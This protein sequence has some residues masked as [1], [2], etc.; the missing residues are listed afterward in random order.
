MAAQSVSKPIGI[1]TR[2]S[3][4]GRRSNEELLSHDLQR[5]KV[6]K[7]LDAR[8]LTASRQ[9]YRDN[10]KS[11][12]SMSR[13]AFDRVLGEVTE[14]KLGG[15]AVAY[16]DRFARTVIEALAVIEK[17]EEAG[18]VV[19]ALDADFDTSTAMGKAMLR[20]SLIFSTLQRDMSIE[21]AVYLAETKLD[22]G[23][24][25]GG[26][27]PVGYRWQ[28]TGSDSNGKDILGWIEP[29]EDAAVV[30][31]ALEGFASGRFTTAGKV[32]D[33]LNAADVTTSKGGRWDRSNIIGLLKRETYTGARRYGAKRIEK[34]HEALIDE[35]THRVIVRRLTPKTTITRKRGEGHIL[36]QG[37]CR[38]GTCGAG[39]T[40]GVANGRYPTL[41]CNSRGVGHTSISYQVAEDWVTSVAFSHG[42]VEDYA[43]SLV[44]LHSRDA[45]ETRVTEAR[46]EVAKVEDM[47]G[48]TLPS[49]STQA[50]ALA[51]AEDALYA[52]DAEATRG[53]APVV[54]NRTQFEALDIAGRIK[55]LRSIVSEVVVFPGIKGSSADPGGRLVVRFQDGAQHPAIW[56]PAS[57][58]PIAVEVTAATG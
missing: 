52:F 8:E 34:A 21:K 12:G 22:A 13:P 54:V 24:S 50:A 45:L 55:A 6:E 56:D 43:D 53:D 7:Y 57:V 31:E 14:G 51:I 17:V 1:Y 36:G 26:R 58:P 5:T 41:R 30:K 40:R 19:I 35:P 20:M 37:L 44:S 32:A 38:C 42:S 27:A 16:L 28:V 33:H 11:G 9:T 49:T 23:T 2:V 46:G 10:D 39:L 18:G 29:S 4:Q 15:L 47:I 3:E 48:T 25:L